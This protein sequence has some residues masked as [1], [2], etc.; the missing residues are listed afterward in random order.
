MTLKG[1]AL[2]EG[3][4][5]RKT[6]YVSLVLVAL[7]VGGCSTVNPGRLY[8][9]ARLS[10]Y[11][12]A[13][14]VRHANSTRDVDAFVQEALSDHGIKSQVGPIEAKP[15]DVDFYVEYVD[16]WRWDLTMYL[17]SLDIRVERNSDGTLLGTGSFKQGFPHSFPDPKRKTHEVV[18][19][20]FAA[21]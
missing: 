9:G 10:D 17:W 19:Q 2:G 21:Q 12:T 4:D 16:H 11:K 5:M 18:D 6:M 20:I 8:N 1:S 3:W 13:Y 7:T 14:V 15:K